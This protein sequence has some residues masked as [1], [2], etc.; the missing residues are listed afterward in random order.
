[1]ASKVKCDETKVEQ[2]KC[3]ND[4]DFLND[5]LASEKEITTNTAT[6]ITEA[7]NRKLENMFLEFF[8]SIEAIQRDTYELAWNNGW[9]TLEQAE[10]T[11]INQK[12]K[13]LQKK[14]DELSK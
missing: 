2:T 1:M 12:A 8:D 5:L 7:S 10:K 9:Y 13:E 11:K 6:A 3:M 4:R 14:L